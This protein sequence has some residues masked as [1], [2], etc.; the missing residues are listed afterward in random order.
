VQAAAFNPDARVAEAMERLARKRDRSL[1]PPEEEHYDASREVRSKGV[2]F[3][4][5]SRDE[6]ARREEMGN[7]EKMRLETERVEAER[8]ERREKKR[9]EMERRKSIIREKRVK[10]EAEKF[11]DGLELPSTEV[12]EG[13]SGS[14][15]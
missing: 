2:G 12:V 13:G 10:K 7:L 3:Y 1:T 14:K 5:F 15:D 6:G 8:A 11:L 9:L 4:Q